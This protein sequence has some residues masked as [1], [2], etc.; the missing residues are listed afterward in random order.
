MCFC[1]CGKQGLTICTCWT[2]YYGI[3]SAFTPVYSWLLVLRGLVGFGNGGLS[4]S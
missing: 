1:L 2:L 4:Q 3:L